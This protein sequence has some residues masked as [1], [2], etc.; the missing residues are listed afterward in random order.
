VGKEVGS[1][2]VVSHG[3]N[4][5]VSILSFTHDFQSIFFRKNGEAAQLRA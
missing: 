2:V 5:A 1:A 3:E 4:H